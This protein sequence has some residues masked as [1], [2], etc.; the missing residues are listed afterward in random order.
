V[1]ELIAGDWLAYTDSE[2][3]TAHHYLRNDPTP[4]EESDVPAGTTYPGAWQKQVMRRLKQLEAAPFGW[5]T[6]VDDNPTVV[7][8]HPTASSPRFIQYTPIVVS[9]QTH[10]LEGTIAQKKFT[11]AVT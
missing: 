4:G 5:I 1:N 10:Q 2:D 3:S 8:M 11:P 7:N 9:P 6:E